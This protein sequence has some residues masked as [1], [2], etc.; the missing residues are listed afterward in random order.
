VSLTVA[1]AAYQRFS[2]ALI[3]HTR[4]VTNANSWQE[5]THVNLE[6]DIVAKYVER[7]T[8]WTPNTPAAIRYRD[9]R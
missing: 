2:V 1:N 7:L 6:V 3:P 8:Q 9:V 4:D 5:G